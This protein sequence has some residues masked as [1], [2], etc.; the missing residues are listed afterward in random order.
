MGLLS[1]IPT[2]QAANSSYSTGTRS[3]NFLHRCRR[4]KAVWTASEAL[5]GQSLPCKVGRGAYPSTM[6]YDSALMGEDSF[7]RYSWRIVI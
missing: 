2:N 6:P 7:S 5:G 3:N 1:P 4:G